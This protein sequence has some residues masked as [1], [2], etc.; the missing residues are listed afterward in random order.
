MARP[1][2]TVTDTF[3]V[4]H[5]ANHLSII[6][7]G[8]GYALAIQAEGRLIVLESVSVASIVF[9]VDGS[10]LSPWGHTMNKVTAADEVD[11]EA[12]LTRLEEGIKSG[13]FKLTDTQTPVEETR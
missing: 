2:I 5:D 11:D 1:V 8:E 6:K 7:D 12:L 10:D 4:K 3:G 9:T 13:R